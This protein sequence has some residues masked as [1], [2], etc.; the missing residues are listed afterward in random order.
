MPKRLNQ[1]KP[2]RGNSDASSMRAHSTH[3]QA[4]R[5]NPEAIDL[6]NEIADNYFELNQPEQAIAALRRGLERATVRG[7]CVK[8]ESFAKRIRDKQ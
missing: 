4:L 1:P 3:Q 6:Y 7:D 5:L 8:T 2:A